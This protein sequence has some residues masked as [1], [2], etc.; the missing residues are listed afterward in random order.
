MSMIEVKTAELIGYALDWAVGVACKDSELGLY[1]DIRGFWLIGP[2]GKP[3]N[4]S[5][6]WSQGGPLIEKHALEI[7][8][9]GNGWAGVKTWCYGEPIEW[10]PEGES[11][12]IAACRAIVAAKLG[13]SVQVPEELIP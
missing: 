12:L 3:W 4:P 8:E 7:I 5:A 13:K 10:F 11:H 2:F 1:P 6:D 9:A